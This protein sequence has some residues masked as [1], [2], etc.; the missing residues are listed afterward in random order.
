MKQQMIATIL[1]RVRDAAGITQ[2]QVADRAGVSRQML[3][4]W[5]N[6]K[7][8][9]TLEHLQAWLDAVIAELK[10]RSKR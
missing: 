3:N 8:I 7:G 1:K 10:R 2:Q 9:P 4:N 5:E 6:S